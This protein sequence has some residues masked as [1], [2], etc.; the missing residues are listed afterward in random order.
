MDLD[1]EQWR[2]LAQPYY[3]VF[4][5]EPKKSAGVTIEVTTVDT[6]LA[7]KLVAP[8]Q[9]LVHDPAIQKG[10]CHEYL[11]FE[12]FFDGGGKGEVGDVGFAVNPG[13][14][15][16]IDM[17]RRYVSAQQ[18]STSR[19]V[20]IPHAT[21]GFAPGEDPPV[22]SV[23]LD[24]PT[25]RI[26]AAAHEALWTAKA[27]GSCDELPVITSAFLELVR[28][29][30]LRRTE[31]GDTAHQKVLPRS[32]FL[33]DYVTR[34]LD[35]PDLDA[36]YLATELGMS[37]AT[38]YRHF[39]NTG[40]VSQYIRNR[41]LDRCFFELAGATPQRGRIKAIA[42]RW[43]FK[44]ASHFNRLFRERFGVSPSDALASRDLRMHRAPSE[45]LQLSQTWLA[46]LTL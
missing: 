6:L 30:M 9:T 40:G 13:N 32:M 1:L 23:A 3:E 42:E 5:R 14:V 17:S 11:L 39:E 36:T 19:G 33:R 21:V 22:Y 29:L 8:A 2:A 35:N 41:R 34:H 24:S 4:P 18:R 43:H 28:R 37:R 12:R 44:D 38:F 46:Q 7:T 26:L 15:H 10:V 31:E 16:M 27:H 20:L 25:G 45:F